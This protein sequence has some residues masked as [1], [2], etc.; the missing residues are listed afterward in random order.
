MLVALWGF[1]LL[2]NSCELA[3]EIEEVKGQSVFIDTCVKR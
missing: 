1:W 2:G 3:E